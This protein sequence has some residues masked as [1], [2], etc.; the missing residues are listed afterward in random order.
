MEGF[1]AAGWRDPRAV[2][3]GRGA[4]SPIGTVSLRRSPLHDHHERRDARFTDFGGWEMPVSFN[5]IQDEHGAVR[6]EAGRSTSPTRRTSR[7][8]PR[9]RRLMGRLTTNDP[10]A[11]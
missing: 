6:E 7:S 5:S 2:D 3:G 10:A 1:A 9:R 11:V 8:V 4:R